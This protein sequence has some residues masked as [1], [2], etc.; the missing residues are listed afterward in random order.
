M[1]LPDEIK[2][3]LDGE[4]DGCIVCGDC[5]EIMAGMPDGCVDA[6]VTDPP[7][8][9][10]KGGTVHLSGRGV[11]AR[12]HDSESVG[13]KWQASLAWCDNAWRACS[14]GVLA[15]CSYH[16]VDALASAM[17]VESRVA[18]MT[19]H[20]RN[21]PVPVNNVPHFTTEFLWAFKKAPGLKWRNWTATM[22]DIPNI[23]AGCVSTGERIVS[24][25]GKALHPTQKPLA[26]ME[27]VLAVGGDLVLDPFSGLG[28]T[29]VA[30]KKL[31][32]RWI[33]IDISE[34]YCA[35]ARKR[36]A[37]TPRPMFK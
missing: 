20:K 23:T 29:C 36:L 8:V 3:V 37:A 28:T 30:A 16:F 35:I 32:R 15:F 34:E 6:V 18:L 5:L 1:T 31:G 14:L 10:L 9:G 22:W 24:P 19:W 13:D 4:S 11:A 2:A 7:Y 33:G 26:L 12:R 17:P 27:E 21:S 25:S